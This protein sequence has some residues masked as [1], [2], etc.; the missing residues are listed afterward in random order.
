MVVKFP[1]K[2]CNRPVSKNHQSTQCDINVK[3]K[4]IK[5][6]C[7]AEKQRSTKIKFFNKINTVSE[8]SEHSG[9]TEYWDTGKIDE[10]EN[11]KNSVNSLHLNISSWPCHFSELQT[12]L[13]ST[14]VNFNIIGIS[15]SRIKQNKNPIDNINLQNYNIKHCTTEATNGGGI[16]LYIKDNI[17][18]KLR[19][20]LKIYKS[21]C[22]ESIFL[23]V[24]NQS[25][26]NIVVGCIYR[27]SFMDLS[28]FNNDYLNSL[29]KK[30]LREKNKHIILMGDFN[31]NLLKY[32]T[33]TST[34]QFLDQMYSSSFLQN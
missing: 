17:I 26:K 22:L 20:D 30:L 4:K 18:Y 19:K 6:T 25:G 9:W 34:A 5:L 3:G 32:T 31:V 12:R 15:E 14:K 33:N 11:N 1:C 10:P 16:L 21:K 27:H 29:S 13:S 28:K 2:I 24:I 8:N 23:E 7:A